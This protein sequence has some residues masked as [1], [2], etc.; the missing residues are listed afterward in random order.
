MLKGTARK[1]YTPG[2]KKL[3]AETMQEEK[4]SDCQT[5][6][7]LGIHCKRVQDRKRIYLAKGPKGSAIERRGRG[8]PKELPKSEPL[9]LQEFASEEHFKLELIELD[10]YNRR[11]MA[12]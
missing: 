5:A 10:Y 8:R 9:Y 2:F 4:L 6:M 11:I 7:R 12:K 1:C 3:A